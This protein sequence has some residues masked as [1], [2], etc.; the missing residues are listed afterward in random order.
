MIRLLFRQKR[1]TDMTTNIRMTRVMTIPAT[2]LL[3]KPLRR[4]GRHDELL[5][6]PTTRAFELS[7][8]FPRAST[9]VKTIGVPDLTFAS[10]VYVNTDETGS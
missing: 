7:P 10:Q 3:E 8:C 2:A 1:N 4:P 5:E 6:F 9:I